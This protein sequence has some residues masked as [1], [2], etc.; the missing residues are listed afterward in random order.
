[1]KERSQFWPKGQLQSLI[2]VMYNG[3]FVLQS[4]NLT[5][6]QEYLSATKQ[7]VL[8][9]GIFNPPGSY[10]A[11]IQ[12]VNEVLNALL[13]KQRRKPPPISSR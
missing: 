2:H 10:Y 5:V 3:E 9:Y 13:L 4:A 11:L 1:M 8:L 6:L 12:S 7:L